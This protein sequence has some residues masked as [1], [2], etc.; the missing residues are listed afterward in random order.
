MKTIKDLKAKIEAGIARQKAILAAL[1]NA[2]GV[3]REMTEAETTE[4]GNIDKANESAFGDIERLEK[5]DRADAR[6]AG[7]KVSTPA[8]PTDDT[9]NIKAVTGQTVPATVETKL[10]SAQTVGVAAW[11]A[12]RNKL[13]PSKTALEHLEAAGFQKFADA[14]RATKESMSKIMLADGTQVKT[15]QTLAGQGGDNAIVTP[16]STDFIEFLRNESVFLSAQPMMVDLSF[17]SLDIPGGNAGATG[18]YN[19]EGA[20]L[21]YVQATTR[22]VNLVAKHIGAITSISN[23]LLEVSPLAMAQITGEDLM[24]G[25]GL[26]LDSAGLRGD[27]TGANPAGVLSLMNAGHKVAATATS[28]T[29]T[30]AAIDADAKTMLT[31]L[32]T[33]NIKKR[34]RRWQ[35]CNRVFTY[36]QFMRDG[37]GNFVFP[38]LQLANPVWYDN[39]PVDVSEQIPSNLG[40]GTNESEIW[41]IDYGHVMMGVARALIMK[42]STEAS[43]KNGG[44]TLV[45]AFARDE[46]VIRAVGSHDFDMRFDKAAV[47]LQ[48]VKWGA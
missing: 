10:T 11:A 18:T 16:L 5:I 1:N 29:P 7:I 17:G 39:I 46:T 26:S 33:S 30:Y 12:A 8:A 38:G 27:G 4:Y 15:L 14:S 42:S 13:Y 44:G 20:D 24:S 19:V 32:R 45:S 35:M 48:A 36:L 40:V 43:Y 41:L 21:A 3:E 23:Y 31:K 37:N 28:L 22:K 2:E 25:V 9:G 6:L 34:R 47:V